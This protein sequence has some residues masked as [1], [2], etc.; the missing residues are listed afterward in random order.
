MFVLDFVK[1]AFTSKEINNNNY[2][3]IIKEIRT[4]LEK[5]QNLEDVTSNN[6]RDSD[7]F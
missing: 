7:L 1:M 2:L 5:N 6:G 4:I 3:D